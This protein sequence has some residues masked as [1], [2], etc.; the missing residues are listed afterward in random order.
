M[1]EKKDDID[2]AEKSGG[3]SK[4]L[5]IIIAVLVIALAAVGA[6]L[7][8]GGDEKPEEAQTTSAAPV[9]SS[10][11]YYAVETPF[12]INFYEQSKGAVRY[13]SVK[14]KVMARDQAVIDTLTLNMPMIQHELLLLFYAQDYQTLSTMGTKDLQDKV[15]ATINET[16]AKDFGANQLEAVY[17][18]SFLMQ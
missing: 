14:L 13:M 15:L 16:L 12:I 10:P 4:L 17:F 3:N 1:A 6:M 5:I 2:V 7:L 18:T 8:M 11:I 9:K